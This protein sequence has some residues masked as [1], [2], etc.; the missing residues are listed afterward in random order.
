MHVILHGAPVIAILLY[1]SCKEQD[2]SRAWDSVKEKEVPCDEMVFSVTWE[3]KRLWFQTRP[4]PVTYTPSRRVVQEVD[5]NGKIL[6]QFTL[7][8]RRCGQN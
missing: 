4:F 7:I 6:S 1:L 2:T 3:E 8:E 5:E